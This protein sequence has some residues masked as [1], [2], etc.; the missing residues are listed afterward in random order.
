MKNVYFVQVSNYL[1]KSLYLP[2]AAGTI[3]AYSFSREEIK[4]NYCFKGFVIEKTDVEKTVNSFENPF[5]IGFSNYVWNIDYNL[6]LAKKVKEIFPECVIC[7]GGPSVPDDT[8]LLSQYSFI[9]I[10]IHGEGETV[11]YELLKA[12]SENSLL[13]DIANIS[14]RLNGVPYETEKKIVCGDLSDYPSPYTSGCFDGIINDPAYEGIQFD[15]LFE[16][17]RGCPYKCTYCTW[18]SKSFRTFSMERVKA[19]LDWMAENKI[20]FVFCVDGNFGMLQRDMEIAEYVVALKK[21]YGYPQRMESCAAKN[22]NDFVFEM[23]LML[24][25][26]GLNRGVSIAVQS[27]SPEV[28]KNVGRQNIKPVDLAFELKRYRE[29]SIT[30]Y[31]DLILGLPGETFESFCDGYFNVIEAGQHT[32]V[33]VYPCEILPNTALYSKKE[34]E[35]FGIKTLNANLSQRHSIVNG[36]GSRTEIVVSTNTLSSDEWA[37]AYK[38]S[39]TVHAFHCLGLIKFLAVYLRKAKNV[40]YKNFYLGLYDYIENNHGRF[41][42]KAI[43]NVFGCVDLFIKGKADLAYVNSDFGNIVFP[44]CEGLFLYCVKNFDEFY[45]EIG[46][47]FFGYFEAGDAEAEDLFA[48]QKNMI[49]RPGE[50]PFLSQGKYDWCEYFR[51]TYDPEFT[52]PTPKEQTL[53]FEGND[54]SDLPEYARM[55]VWLGRRALKTI[56][57]EPTAEE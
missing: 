20:S 47:Y 22:K 18:A 45:S 54:Y 19:D 21:K 27:M 44:F 40:S 33:N 16:T 24:E 2:Y 25:K 43:D 13:S 4:K 10:L 31:T 9:D 17:N 49:T 46:K 50:K 1:S 34:R 29:N 51:H 36:Q 14:Y 7:F 55:I 30:T 41:L 28:L 57:P 11:V 12:Y 35:R 48:Y 23:N 37:K 15:A 32:S 56:K 6:E 39:E 3:V 53:K 42:K 38:I 26:A 5:F 52:R 8:E